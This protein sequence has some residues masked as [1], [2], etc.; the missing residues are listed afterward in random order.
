MK[1]IVTGGS[2]RLGQSV[3]RGLAASHEVV[4]IDR[5]PIAGLPATQLQVDLADIDATT[6]AFRKIGADALVHL[7]A[8][9]V[10][11]SAPEHVIL[12][13][14]LALAY[15]AISAA[16]ASGA[17][18]ILAASSPTL[19]GYGRP[20]GW[21]P[22]YLPIDETHR[23]EPWN[24]YALSKQAIEELIAMFTRSNGDTV[25]YGAF[26]PCFVISPDEWDGALTQQGHTVA[27]RLDNPELA[28]VSLFNYVDARDAADFVGAW[29]DGAAAVPNGQVFFVGAQDALARAP[30]A[31]LVPHYLP[32][33]GDAAAH[34]TGT[35]PA[36]SSDLATSLLGWSA[37]R[38]WRTELAGTA[39][40][41]TESAPSIT[42][43][44]SSR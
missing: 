32:L 7:A 5:H 6:T 30:L 41:Q 21:A 4:S 27:D 9:S 19:I 12:Q 8:I 35:A 42:T 26:R 44:G 33:L 11:F 28:A 36:F 22:E 29:L 13:T 15:S 37:T 2:G 23:L 43:V 10:P 1:I 20:G 39:T 24:A 18:L 34:L 38:S 16:T 17:R 14:N 25:T 31:E 3:V 40:S